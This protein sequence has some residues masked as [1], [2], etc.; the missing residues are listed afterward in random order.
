[1]DQTK[2][3]YSLNSKCPVDLDEVLTYGNEK[4]KVARRRWAILAKALKG[5]F[6]SSIVM[7]L[8]Q[9]NID[10]WQA[11]D[12]AASPTGSQ[13]SS[14]TDEISVRRISS[15]M[16][17]KTQQLPHIPIASN[18]E[19]VDVPDAL[20][21]RTWYKYSACIEGR[22]YF[23]NVGHRNRTFSGNIAVVKHK[24][25]S[26]LSMDRPS[27]HPT[28][29]QAFQAIT[30]VGEGQSP[31]YVAGVLDLHHTTVIRAVQCFRET[32]TYTR[33]PGHRATSQRDDNFVHLSVLRNRTFTS[34]SV[35][36]LL[37]KERRVHISDRTARRRL[38]P[39]NLTNRRPATG[40]L[41]TRQ[42]PCRL[43]FAR[44]YSGWTVNYC[45]VV[46]FT[47][48]TKIGLR[49]PD[50]RS[51]VWKRAAEDLMGFNNTGNVCI[52]PSEETLSYYVCSN[53]AQFRDKT[54]IELGG[55]MSCLAGLFVAKYGDPKEVTVTDGNKISVENVQ[56][57]LRCN[58]FQVP[59]HCEVLKWS[60]AGPRTPYNIVLCADCLFFDDARADLIECLRTYMTGDG[61]A[62][63]M[64]PQRGRTLDDFMAQSEM[65]GLRCE[66]I[67][68]Y[69][70]VVWE[71]RLQLLDHEE[72]DDNIH[73]PILIR[74]TKV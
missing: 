26:R 49:S 54:V 73:Y 61:V 58:D 51:R 9:I 48:E 63:V 57:T 55:G 67:S 59:V 12:S 69:N 44:E 70:E 3:I 1:M 21:K 38:H 39:A 23:V 10:I 27:R 32:G 25:F 40:P 68:R 29:N 53:L 45:K 35:N 7:K 28:E 66:K 43:R 56:A 60:Q 18:R 64:A 31:H 15:F 19:I 6:V 22:E 52:W 65:R 8:Y 37:R 47:D 36:D 5:V 13:P 14:P 33:R 17:L 2:D 42:Q 11:F 41:L 74:V 62:L 20:K 16:L 34:C 30:L 24:P 71:R 50:G 4:K 46:L 72:Y